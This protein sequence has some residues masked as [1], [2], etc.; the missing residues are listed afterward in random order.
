[1]TLPAQHPS[2]V[3]PRITG[4]DMCI[5]PLLWYSLASSLDI[6]DGLPIDLFRIFAMSWAILIVI[7][8]ASWDSKSGVMATATTPVGMHRILDNL[9]DPSSPYGAIY[10]CSGSPS[11][12]LR[13]LFGCRCQ[14]SGSPTPSQLSAATMAACCDAYH[15]TSSRR[16]P[17]GTTQ[18]R[19]WPK[20]KA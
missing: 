14:P 11:A 19:A 16:S 13:P 20:V 1:M 7:N 5:F 3:T 17:P 4:I 2:Q 9:H 12:R 6:L 10:S 8:G 15:H 18:R